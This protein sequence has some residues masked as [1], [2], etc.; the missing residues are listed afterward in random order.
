VAEAPRFVVTETV[1][2]D[3]HVIRVTDTTK[4]NP[5]QQRFYEACDEPGAEEILFDGSIRLGK[6]QA[7]CKKIVEWAWRYGGRYCVARKTYNELIDSTMKI[8]MTGEGAMPPALPPA[9]YDPS[10]WLKSERTVRLKNGAEIMFRNLE[11]AEEGRAKLR[12]ISL[13]AMFIDQVEELDGPDWA[14]FYEELNGRLSDPRGPG[15]MLLAANPGPTDHWVYQRFIDEETSSKF[16]QCRYV[17]GT[18]YDN[19]ENLDERYFLSRVRT[20]TQNPEYFKRMV[21]G[22]WGSFGSKRFK[23]FAKERHVCDP[24]PIPRHW[25]VIEGLDY[26]Y[27]HPF[28]VLWVAVDEYEHHFVLA[29]H[30]VKERPVGW[31]AQQMHAVREAKQVKPVVTWADPMIF[32]REARMATNTISI[33]LSD[34]GIFC[35]QANSDRLSGWARIDELLTENRLS[36]FSTCP[37]LIKELPNLRMKDNSD[38][39]EKKNDDLSDALRYAVQSRTPAARVPDEGSEEE[40]DDRRSLHHSRVMREA[41]DRHNGVGN[42]F[43]GVE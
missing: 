23:V 22:E 21:L 28:A 38:D 19:R 40:H 31:H 14:E 43:L 15:K 2:G 17:H 27:S 3:Y 1:E 10:G 8:M 39:V 37:Q 11:S 7:A 4:P 33:E 29:E 35:A 13:N 30:K 42:I 9:L 16:P 24:F 12:N 6:T 5:V 20:E 32:F 26:G 25:E 36:I 34:H 41:L 18:L